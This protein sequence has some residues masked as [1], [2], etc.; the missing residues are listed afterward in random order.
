MGILTL[1]FM[2]NDTLSEIITHV[3]NAVR[4]KS[5]GVKIAKTRTTSALAKILLQEGFIDEVVDSYTGSSHIETRSKTSLFLR[6][7]YYGQ[8]HTPIITNIQR[9]SRVSLRIYSSFD[10]IP[11]VLGGIG[12]IILS[13]S[14]GLITDREA[15]QRGLGGE[16]LCS[17]W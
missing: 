13:T 15:I 8:R 2:T 7:K 17:I 14:Q 6:L 16:L 12:V 5:L 10:E 4:N 9:V 11:Q 1:F 3:R